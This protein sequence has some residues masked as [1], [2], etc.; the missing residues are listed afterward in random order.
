MAVIARRTG[1]S[2]P[3]ACTQPPAGPACPPDACESVLQQRR[4]C[5]SS[6]AVPPAVHYAVAPV[7]RG[8]CGQGAPAPHCHGRLAPGTPSPTRHSVPGEGVR[9]QG[10]PPLGVVREALPASV[11]PGTHAMHGRPASVQACDSSPLTLSNSSASSVMGRSRTAMSST[12]SNVVRSSHRSSGSHRSRLWRSSSCA[13]CCCY[14][15]ERCRCWGT[16]T[17]RRTRRPAT[18]RCASVPS[19][20]KRSSLTA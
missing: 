2:L 7:G 18:W 13:P 19:Q 17:A 6:P 14:R 4:R 16:T 11:A 1:G 8:A 15:G 12:C 3:S 9:E 5:S 20:R 10:L